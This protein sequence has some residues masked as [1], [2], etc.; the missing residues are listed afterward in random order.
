MVLD[1]H[2]DGRGAV[3]QLAGAE[4]SALSEGPQSS[5]F[6]PGRSASQAFL[7][8]VVVVVTGVVLAPG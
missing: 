2:T 5:G 3:E 8:T 6:P 4:G 7:E 1:P